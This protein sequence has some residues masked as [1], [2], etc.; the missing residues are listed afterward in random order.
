M[1]SWC[2]GEINLRLCKVSFLNTTKLVQYLCSLWIISFSISKWFKFIFGLGAPSSASY[3]GS[4]HAIQVMFERWNSL[5]TCTTCILL[6]WNITIISFFN[7]HFE[8][9]FVIII[10]LF[11]FKKSNLYSIVDHIDTC[12]S[13]YEPVTNYWCMYM[14]MLR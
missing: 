3:T 4:K 10:V 13:M 11:F 12:T 7:Y 8:Y 2:F 1:L 6:S 9:S 5:Y 14:Y